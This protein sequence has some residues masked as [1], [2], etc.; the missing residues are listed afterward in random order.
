MAGNSNNYALNVIVN[1]SP[2]PCIIFRNNTA[3]SPQRDMEIFKAILHEAFMMA[4]DIVQNSPLFKNRRSGNIPFAD[5]LR[6]AMTNFD[7]TIFDYVPIPQNHSGFESMQICPKT[8]WAQFTQYSPSDLQEK[9]LLNR[10]ED[11]NALFDN[12]GNQEIATY[13]DEPIVGTEF[14][15]RMEG[16]NA[17][18]GNIGN[19]EIVTYNDEPIVGMDGSNSIIESYPSA[20]SYDSL[21]NA[22]ETAEITKLAGSE[23]MGIESKLGSI[24]GGTKREIT[25]LYWIDEMDDDIATIAFGKK[26]RLC[27]ETQG[28]KKGETVKAR[29]RWRSGRK[30]ADNSAEL[31]YSGIV[32]E[33]GKAIS[34]EVWILNEKGGEQSPVSFDRDALFER[35]AGLNSSTQKDLLTEPYDYPFNDNID[36]EMTGPAADS[37]K[38]LPVMDMGSKLGS[39]HGGTKGEITEL[40]WIDETDNKI[41]TIASDKKARLCFETQ[42]YKKGETVKARVKWYS[43]NKFADN[44]TELIYSGVVDE[45]GKAISEE[46]WMLN[47]EGG[48]QSLVS[49]DL[50]ANLFKR[51][52]GLNSSTQKDLLS[53]LNDYQPNNKA[54]IKMMGS[55][56]DSGKNLPVMATGSKLGSIQGGTEKKITKMYW[57]DE[58][59]RKK[60]ETIVP[61]QKAFLCF[62]T[63]GY[64]KGDWVDADVKWSDGREFEDGLT[65]LSFSGMVDENGK[66]ISI[67]MYNNSDACNIEDDDDKIETAENST[68]EEVEIIIGRVIRGNPYVSR[69]AKYARLP[70]SLPLNK[71]YQ[72]E[73]EVKGKKTVD[74]AIINSDSNNGSATITPSRITA[75]QIVTIKGTAMTKEGCGG[76]LRIEAKVDGVVKAV[77]AGFSVCCHPVYFINTFNSD[78]D[79]LE[80][81]GVVVTDNWSSDN[82]VFSDLAGTEISEI[83]SYDGKHDSPP[84]QKDI[85]ANNSKYLAGDAHTIDTHSISRG[86]I[87][88]TKEGISEA[89]QLSIYRCSRCGAVDIVMPN[90]GF[91]R[92]HSVYKD[93]EQWKHETKKT[94]ANVTIRKHSTGAG[95]ANVTSPEHELP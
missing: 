89:Y 94:G 20:K 47:E 21:S 83:V 16:A 69:G 77:S 10:M 90:S 79:T 13:N 18:F 87:E 63:Q 28:Y 91:K 9:E 26:A 11:A 17:S 59:T 72:V 54:D 44:P 92:I 81:L 15:N 31:I 42:G 4:V 74:L 37:E 80:D 57:I 67:Q 64:K 76:N 84:F 93:G 71:T 8:D 25:E 50:G 40:Y 5:L 22:N 61:D 62:E 23:I 43:S 2:T 35:M 68:K 46:V 49:F 75:T 24:H 6:K 88:L 19:Q 38:N 58:K 39:I 86:G 34:K 51:I 12:I 60:I 45:N 95:N 70:D 48:E 65:K 33:N 29:V 27:F 82:G 66:A 41:K 55:A 3:K 30:F 73:V 85:S 36:I 14:P 52:A 53:E 1:G 32:D 56:V 78:L 7:N